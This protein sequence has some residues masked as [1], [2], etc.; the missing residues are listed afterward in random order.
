MLQVNPTSM[1]KT[2]IEAGN[3]QD[4]QSLTPPQLLQYWQVVLRWKWV[5]IGMVTSS[6]IVGLVATLLMTPKY[7]AKARIEIS[8]AQKNVTKVEG[9]DDAATGRDLEF[10]QTQYSLLE[11]RSLAERVSRQLRLSA[12]DPFFEANGVSDVSGFFDKSNKSS[13]AAAREKREL[14]AVSLLL[15]N[16]GVAP[17]RGSAL[18]DVSY[19]SASPTLSAKI[20]DTWT[21]QFIASSMDRRFAST[22]DGTVGARLGILRLA[23]GN[24]VARPFNWS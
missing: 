18:V 5:I 13:P 22:S 20:A 8:R 21:Q 24:R 17:I 11:A 12:S 7:T 23:E 3:V 16:V 4:Q 10:Y 14:L 9:L 1:A 2:A 6:L 19:T 15:K